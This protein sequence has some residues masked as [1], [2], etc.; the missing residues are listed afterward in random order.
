MFMDSWTSL[1]FDWIGPE[2]Q[3]AL[4]CCSV[5][6]ALAARQRWRSSRLWF[7]TCWYICTRRSFTLATVFLKG[8]GAADF[9]I[10]LVFS[11]HATTPLDAYVNV[12]LSTLVPFKL[13]LSL[14][15]IPKLPNVSCTQRDNAFLICLKFCHFPHVFVPECMSIC[16][17]QV[18]PC[19]RES[20]YT[21]AWTLWR[22][23]NGNS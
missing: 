22:A 23:C 1:Q 17:S 12:F 16:C 11:I 18:L 3:L 20:D 15:Y 4:A 14:C 8:K 19:V 7:T 6:P 5:Y 9:C 13:M 21:Q 10:Q 2:M